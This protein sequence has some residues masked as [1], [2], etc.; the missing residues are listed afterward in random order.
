MI[1]LV[2]EEAMGKTALA[3]KVYNRLDVRQHFK[4][5][6][7]LHV[8]KNIECKDLLIVL[9]KQIP[10]ELLKGVELMSEDKLSAL[11]FQT[12]IELRFL[13]VLDNVFSFDVWLMLACPFADAANGSRVILTTRDSKISSDVDLWSHPPL[14]IVLEQVSCR[15]TLL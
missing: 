2:S 15:Q 13:I 8:P 7:W 3:R 10:M 1:S 4:C 12:L 6:V 14:G 11:H 5:H 9:L